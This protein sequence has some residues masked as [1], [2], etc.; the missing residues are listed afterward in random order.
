MHAWISTLI[1]GLHSPK[2]R[3]GVTHTIFTEMAA[4]SVAAHRA[5]SP[6]W[7]PAIT[8]ESVVLLS[9]LLVHASPCP[10]LFPVLVHYL[11]ETSW[12]EP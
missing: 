4:D 9:D 1:G 7:L 8:R 10:V 12:N 11:K 3:E 6:M 5:N 2:S